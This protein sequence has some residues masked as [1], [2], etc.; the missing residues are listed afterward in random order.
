[1][2]I[3][4]IFLKIQSVFVLI[5]FLIY[6]PEILVDNFTANGLKYT[7]NQILVPSY[8]IFRTQTIQIIN[9]IFIFVK[10]CSLFSIFK[11]ENVCSSRYIRQGSVSFLFQLVW[12]VWIS[13]LTILFKCTRIQ[14]IHIS[15]NEIKSL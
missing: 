13:N 15:I 14:F 4:C 6:L 3:H 8:V 1:M 12:Q 9:I 7:G 10:R 11:V 5:H 2:R